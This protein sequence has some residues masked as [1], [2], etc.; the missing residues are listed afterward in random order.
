MLPKASVVR[1]LSFHAA[2][3]LVMARAFAAE[4]P[5]L[6]EQG[7]FFINGEVVRTENP[8]GEAPAGRVIVNQMYVEYAVPKRQKAGAVPFLLLQIL[9]LT[10]HCAHF[11]AVFILLLPPLF[12]QLFHASGKNVHAP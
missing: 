5:V 2:A 8:G 11:P 3:L 6:K 4:P 1:L 10:M 7:S 12:W 9:S